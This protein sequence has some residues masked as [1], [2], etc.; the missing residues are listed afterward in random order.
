MTLKAS[1]TLALGSALAAASL[2]GCSSSFGSGGGNPPAKTYV[3]LPS[4]QAVPADQY[5]GPAVSP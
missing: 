4:G 3:V 2:G 5:R 1:L